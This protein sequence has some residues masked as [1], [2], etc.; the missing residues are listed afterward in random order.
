M[1]YI[2]TI[3]WLRMHDE[4]GR[5]GQTRRAGDD[6]IAP[7]RQASFDPKSFLAKVSAPLAALQVASR[8]VTRGQRRTH[9]PK[10]GTHILEQGLTLNEA[11]NAQRDEK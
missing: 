7:K 9:L 11:P 1:K 10:T 3:Q 4:S 8:W 2:C 5:Y 6:V